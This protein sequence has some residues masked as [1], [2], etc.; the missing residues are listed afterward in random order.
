MFELA[1]FP[2]CKMWAAIKW[3]SIAASRKRRKCF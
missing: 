2:T 3:I 1:L